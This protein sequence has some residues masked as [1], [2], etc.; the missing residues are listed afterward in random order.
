MLDELRSMIADPGAA[1]EAEKKKIRRRLGRASIDELSAAC[2]GSVSQE[3]V[4]TH[5]LRNAL[6]DQLTDEVTGKRIDCDAW[7]QRVSDAWPD[8]NR[9]PP[10]NKEEA[11]DPAG[12]WGAAALGVDIR[13]CGDAA[14]K[15]K[16]A[17]AARA[18]SAGS[19][20]GIYFGEALTQRQWAVRHGWSVGKAPEQLTDEEAHAVEERRA[21][22]AALA[23]EAP[24]GGV[25]NGGS[26]VFDTLKT[27]ATRPGVKPIGLEERPV[28][29]DGEDPSR[30]SWCRFIN[31]AHYGSSA[32]NL[33]PRSD[34]SGAK[35][36]QP[37]VWFVARRDIQPGE[38]LC[39]CCASSWS[40]SVSRLGRPIPIPAALPPC[41]P[42]LPCLLTQRPV[43]R[44]PRSADGPSFNEWAGEQSQ[45]RQRVG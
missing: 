12:P 11:I 24:M 43:D 22:L 29:I 3:A 38:E 5:G 36:G 6:C 10:Q 15:G 37:L 28:F 21:R 44:N 40:R 23:D 13:D 32:C 2:I 17:F 4:L 25:D 18:V 9:P 30:S 8:A 34:P 16:G 45:G 41:L 33:S 19:L 7:L 42:C 27:A 14:S 39:F 31:H 26:Y 1:T 35:A 20:M